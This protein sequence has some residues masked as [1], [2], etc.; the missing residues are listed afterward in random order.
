MKNDNKK[1]VWVSTQQ[2]KHL[3]TQNKRH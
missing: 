2:Q 1:Q 3:Q